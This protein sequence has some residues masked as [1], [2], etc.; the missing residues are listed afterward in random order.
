MGSFLVRQADAHYFMGDD[1]EA[2]AAAKRAL[3]QPGF[4]WSRYAVLIAG[5]GRMGR[6]GEAVDW[7]DVVR[8]DRADFSVDF[9]RDTHL[10]NDDAN[11]GAYLAG[12]RA[13]GVPEH[14]PS[15][16]TND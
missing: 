1:E 4:Q 8:R 9:V 16:P 6:L 10:F 14:R 7:L 3:Q 12:L 11:M 13:A 2:V 15:G 5:L